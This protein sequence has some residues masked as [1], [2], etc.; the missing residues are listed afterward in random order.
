MK[1]FF[2]LALLVAPLFAATSLQQRV[3]LSL[4]FNDTRG[5]LLALE[6]LRQSDQ[7]N[8][9]ETLALSFEYLAAVHD[10]DGLRALHE[11]HPIQLPSSTLEQIAWAVIRS[12]SRAYHPKIRAEA[13]LAAALTNDAK[14]MA[15]LNH[16]LDDPHLGIQEMALQL[17]HQFPD[18]PIQQH[19]EQLCHSA[20]P[21]IKLLAAET[22]ASQ[23][24]ACAPA[25]LQ[26]LLADDSL[27][28]DDQI[29][30]ASLLSSFKKELDLSWLASAV[31]DP[32]PAWR[33]LAASSVLKN[34]SKEALLCIMPLAN[35]SS[36]RV[37]E[38]AFEALGLWRTLLPEKNAELSTLFEN[39]LNDPSISVAATAAWALLI[40]EEHPVKEW[41]EKRILSSSK[42]ERICTTSH[43]VATGT[44]GL[45]LA[46]ALL[47]TVKDPICQINLSAYLLH[48]RYKP[49][50]AA[51]ELRQALQKYTSPLSER[52]EGLFSALDASTLSHHPAIPRLPES[53]DLLLR[54]DLLALRCYADQQI[55]PSEIEKMLSDRAWGISASA[56][57]FLFQEIAPSLDEVLTPLL[58]HPTESIRI[59]AAILLT[60]IAKSHHAASV[61]QQQYETASKDGKEMLIMG[62][63]TLPASK[64][65]PYLTPLLF[66]TSPSIRTRA[67]GAMLASLYR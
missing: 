19:A 56:A 44:Q 46:H 17:A 24:A 6:E 28:E 25:V 5:A 20:S 49:Q 34:P 7:A 3:R 36:L 45:E 32:R 39:H 59:Q 14:G 54:L 23:K 67:A 38:Y 2:F 62:F 27:S 43:L 52:Q 64:S 13:G 60:L 41:F 15:I 55:D 33:A 1:R 53:Q 47:H 26:R 31:A 8:D 10:I 37:K 22:L 42:E 50:E 57:G 11:A 16:L 21:Q 9:P 58:S 4:S 51:E 12:S 18:E 48:H 35:D 61:L 29:G 66:D 30:I 63:S 40:G 65:L